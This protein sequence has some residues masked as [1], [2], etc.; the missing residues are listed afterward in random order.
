M[1]INVNFVTD[2]R[3]LR[4]KYAQKIHDTKKTV[5]C[6]KDNVNVKDDDN[7]EIKL[8]AEVT[9]GGINA[10]NNSV[11]FSEIYR[12]LLENESNNTSKIE[13]SPPEILLNKDECNYNV[14]SSMD[15][16][17]LDI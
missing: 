17:T 9:K 4:Q 6:T 15:E 11:T 5:Y 14:L 12:Q 16:E 3:N 8:Y 7:Q 2:S 1:K 13:P 10:F